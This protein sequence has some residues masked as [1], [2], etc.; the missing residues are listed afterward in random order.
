[1]LSSQLLAAEGRTRPYR[2]V[3]IHPSAGVNWSGGSETFSIEMARRLSEYFEVELLSGGPCGAWSTRSGGV[4]RTRAWSAFRHPLLV[5]LWQRFTDIP[6]IW[7]EHLTNYFPCLLHLLKQPADLI[8]PN[9]GVGG[10]AVAWTV[11]ALVGTPMLYTEHCGLLHDGRILARNLAFQPDQLVVFYDEMAR[12]ARSRRPEQAV[13]VIHNGVDTR[14]FSPEGERV[15]L[16]LSGPVVLCVASLRRDGHKRLHLAIE[17]MAKVPEASLL[18]CG[19]GPDRTYYEQLASEKIGAGRYRICTF[20]FEQ[21]P[22]V[23]RACHA[24]TLPSIDEPCAL[25]Q[26]EALASGLG[27][28]ATDDS[29]RRQIVGEGGLLCDVTDS[30]AYAECLRRILSSERKDKAVRSAERFSWDRLA[31]VYRDVIV[32]T[33]SRKNSR[34]KK[35]ETD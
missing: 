8:F 5:P 28:V 26:L 31:L 32:Q 14:R 15:E 4:P 34:F 10:L 23:Y 18:I 27:I 24:F 9:D 30:D 21:M 7:W 22:A 20:P 17:A 12:F 29:S 2:V 16:D 13:S 25:S 35:R 33:I 1:M 19:D 3:L 11:R 6:E